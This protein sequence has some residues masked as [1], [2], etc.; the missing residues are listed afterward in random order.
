MARGELPFRFRKRFARVLLPVPRTPAAT[1]MP[2]ATKN[3]WLVLPPPRSV[4]RLRLFCIAH[5]GG[6]ASAFRGWAEYLPQHVEVCPVQ[7]PGRENR[8]MEK[9]FDRVE[10]LVDALFAAMQQAM[11]LPYAIFGHS[12][13]ALIGFE[14]ARRARAAGTRMPEHLFASGRRAPDL[15]GRTRDVHTLPESELLDEIKA[16]GGIPDEV[17]AHPE[18]RALIVP[19]LRADMALTETYQVGDAP[20]LPIPITGYAGAA[21]PKVPVEDVQAWSRHTTAEFRLRTFPGGHFFV[22]DSRQLVLR[23]L[24]DDLARIEV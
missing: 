8:V 16:L 12:N 23:T 18:L 10:P 1:R 3:A 17:L 5:A 15:P 21:D 2:P 4:T 19:L 14:L 9:P 20:P 6:G 22:F 11:N 13:G 7:L 24:A